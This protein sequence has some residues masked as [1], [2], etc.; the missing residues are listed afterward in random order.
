MPIITC[1]GPRIDDVGK[2]RELAKAITDAA[3]KAFGLPKQAMIVLFK[4]NTA[5]N[6]AVG[7]E[8]LC[9]RAKSPQP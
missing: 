4:E 6:V 9:D 8:L 3:A 7:G 2:K 5:D 1:D